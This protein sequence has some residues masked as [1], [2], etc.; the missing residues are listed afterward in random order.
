MFSVSPSRSLPTLAALVGR[1][2]FSTRGEGEVTRFSVKKGELV[3]EFAGLI[4]REK[5]MESRARL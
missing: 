4:G 5:F 1:C 3:G 2:E